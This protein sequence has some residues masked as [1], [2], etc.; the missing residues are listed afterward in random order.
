MCDPKMVVLSPAS[1][2]S[3]WT[4]LKWIITGVILGLTALA[5]FAYFTHWKPVYSTLMGLAQQVAGMDVNMLVGQIWEWIQ[6][7]A[8]IIGASVSA[9]LTA[10]CPSC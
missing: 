5:A 7:N 3:A 9:I 8:T 1:S 2:T 6:K 10:R 4:Y